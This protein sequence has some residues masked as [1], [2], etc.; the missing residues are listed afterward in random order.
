MANNPSYYIKGR[1]GV[2]LIALIYPTTHLQRN[3]FILCLFV[4]IEWL[5]QACF[6]TWLWLRCREAKW[7]SVGQKLYQY[8]LTTV[9]TLRTLITFLLV[10]LPVRSLMLWVL[11][12]F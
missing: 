8:S 2:H 7:L 11:S 3:P 9:H 1:E 6:V 12:F 10:N 5:L 4:E